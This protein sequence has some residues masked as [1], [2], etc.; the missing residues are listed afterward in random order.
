MLIDRTHRRD[1]DASDATAEVVRVQL[2]RGVGAIT[3]ERI[4]A[5]VPPKAVL[6]HTLTRL[7]AS[8]R[9]ARD[10]A[11]TDGRP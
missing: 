6:Q 3:W 4:D 11:R 5:S 9:P 2:N 1:G 10:H 7:Q 8:S